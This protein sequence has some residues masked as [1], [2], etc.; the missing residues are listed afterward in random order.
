MTER[1]QS[2]HPGGDEVA[3]PRSHR[4]DLHEA[5]VP[6]AHVVRH[7]VR[8]AGGEGGGVKEAAVCLGNYDWKHK[9][10]R[11]REGKE[12]GGPGGEGVVVPV[13]QEESISI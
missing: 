12:D 6:D 1:F 9:R 3:H 4:G 10:R 2:D 13:C 5:L 8:P 7:H 11:Q